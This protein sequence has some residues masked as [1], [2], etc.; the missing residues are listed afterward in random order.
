MEIVLAED[1]VLAED[2]KA[3][4]PTMDA[5]LTEAVDMIDTNHNMMTIPMTHLIQVVAPIA[6]TAEVAEPVDTLKVAE[7]ADTPTPGDATQRIDSK[8]QE[9][10]SN[11]NVRKAMT[12]TSPKH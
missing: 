12:A 4:N 2:M 3:G 9:T 10:T 1:T 7:A 6:P 8:Q 5:N 11:G